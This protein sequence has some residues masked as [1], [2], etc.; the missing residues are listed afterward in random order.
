MTGLDWFQART[1]ARS[2]T[3]VRRDAWRKWLTF[4]SYVWLITQPVWET[5]PFDRRVVQQWDFGAAEFLAT[6]EYRHFNRWVEEVAARPA[7]QRGRRVNRTPTEKNPTLIRERH[8]A[9]DLD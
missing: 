7:V 9:A 2:G 3:A 1:L 5:Q 4:E 6:H 8:S